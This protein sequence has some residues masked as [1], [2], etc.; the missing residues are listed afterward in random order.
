MIQHDSLSA[1]LFIIFCIILHYFLDEVP[2]EG[3]AVIVD[4]LF[5]MDDV[6]LAANNSK[7]AQKL[8]DVTFQVGSTLGLLLNIKKSRYIVD[9][10][11]DEFQLTFAAK[12]WR[13]RLNILI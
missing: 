10:R 7:G 13:T 11:N 5:H 3:T 2:F 1:Q 6:V 9:N 8:L 12:S 4:N